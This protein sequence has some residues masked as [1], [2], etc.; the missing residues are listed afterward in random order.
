MRKG[1]PAA[2]MYR[3]TDLTALFS[4]SSSAVNSSIRRRS[5]RLTE[6]VEDLTPERVIR[7]SDLT[8]F[9]GLLRSQIETLIAEG[10]FPM[11]I[12]LGRAVEGLACE[13]NR[14]VAARADCRTRRRNR[15][16]GARSGEE[17]PVRSSVKPSHAANDNL[18]IPMPHAS[19]SGSRASV[20]ISAA[21]TPGRSPQNVAGF[22]A[23]LA[24]WSRAETPRSGERHR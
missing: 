4:G 11:P 9:V 3:K 10:S 19:R 5:A 6:E 13:R 8:A 22:F 24:E 12:R 1:R 7:L 16:P 23:V 20:P 18:K 21:K 14:G 15:R 17:P 2:A